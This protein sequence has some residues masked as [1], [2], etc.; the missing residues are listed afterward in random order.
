MNK[1]IKKL[2]RNGWNLER[3]TTRSFYVY[4]NKSFR[5]NFSW[6]SF[7]L[8]SLFFNIFGLV[9]YIICYFRK[10]HVENR[11]VPKSFPEEDWDLNV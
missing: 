1:D 5:N 11:I 8:L 6:A 10:P 4:R 9:G 7:V 2:K 3:E